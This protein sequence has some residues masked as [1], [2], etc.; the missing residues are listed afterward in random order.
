MSHINTIILRLDGEW[1]LGQGD[2][3]RATDGDEYEEVVLRFNRCQSVLPQSPHPEKGR[4][5][6]F[7]NYN[8]GMP[9]EAPE[10]ILYV[11]RQ[12]LKPRSWLS[13]EEMTLMESEVGTTLIPSKQIRGWFFSDE[14]QARLMPRLE[15]LIFNHSTFKDYGWKLRDG[16]NPQMLCGCPWHGGESGT[17]FQYSVLTGL[18]DC[19]ACA[20]GGDPLDFLH[21]IKTGD[22][23]AG[24]PR[25]PVL[26]QYVAELAPELGYKYPDDAQMVQKTTVTS[27][28][29]LVMG[30]ELFHK[31]L[32]EI[33]K[34]SPNPAVAKDKMASLAQQTGRRLNGIDCIRAEQEYRSYVTTTKSNARD[35]HD[36]P[37]MT[38]TIPNLMMRPSQIIM[39]AAPGKGK[40]SAAMGFARMVGRGEPMMIRGI[41]VPVPAGK[42]LWV[43]NDQNPA[44][45]KRDCEDNGIDPAKDSD[46]F[47]VKRGFQMN[48]LQ[49]L[50]EW[51]NEIKPALV[52]I[53]SIGSCSTAMQEQEKD[54]AFASPLYHY[55]NMNGEDLELGGFHPCTILWI[56][57]DNAQGEVRG[58]RY[59]TAAVDEQWHLRS[60]SEEER[61]RLRESGRVASNCRFIQVKKSRLGR[62][63]DC[64]VV[65][66]DVDGVY[67]VWDHTPTER[68]MDEGLGD[69]DPSTIALRIVRDRSRG[70]APQEQR[71][72]T[73]Q[74]VWEQLVEEVT[75]Q[76]RG[77]PAKRS[78]KRWLNRWVEDGVLVLGGLVPE[79]SKN[80][81]TPTYLTPYVPPSRVGCEKGGNLSTDGSN[82]SD[83]GDLSV[84]TGSEVIHSVHRSQEQ[85][86][87]DTPVHPR[88]R[89]H[90]SFPVPARDLPHLWTNAPISD[91]DIGRTSESQDETPQE[92][93]PPE[94]GGRTNGGQMVRGDCQD[95]VVT[96]GASAPVT[97][98][99]GQQE[100]PPEWF[101]YDTAFR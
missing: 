100:D 80:R 53:D 48:Y 72:M 96:G 81:R 8:G 66:R 23:F 68:R 84:D 77:A 28:P 38:F 64:L 39:H 26:E 12:H 55:A 13:E 90:R 59:L 71:Q 21:K 79:G 37:D 65:E 73:C 92:V 94:D 99:G 9:A 29:D 74:E 76:G 24:R 50:T 7:L 41:K 6:A 67:S 19:K 98:E 54:K 89:V 1:S 35:W 58:T 34:E 3:N 61:Q 10:W 51:I 87:V 43:Q 16:K 49:D 46:W 83:S 97:P 95:N 101:N 85:L 88:E 22:K 33:I 60:L 93:H 52:V 31:S 36:I 56:H 4:W 32:S 14:V 18:W 15:D 86:S 62:E 40:T 91:T 20:I 75:G 57:H 78:V 69:P 82:P 11:I 42:V 25:G 70:D 2:S 47:V 30:A 17:A 27:R 5:Y 45:L 63:G 44:K